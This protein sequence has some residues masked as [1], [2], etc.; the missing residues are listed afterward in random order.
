MLQA[1]ARHIEEAR[2]EAENQAK[3]TFIGSFIQGIKNRF[4]VLNS[5][6]IM[7]AVKN[8]NPLKRV[9]RDWDLTFVGFS[10]GLVLMAMLVSS[11]K[12]MT[13]IC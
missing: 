3:L 6:V 2:R 11:K 10:Y 7:T 13:V 8:N 12:Y 9:R 4:A 5:L 1:R